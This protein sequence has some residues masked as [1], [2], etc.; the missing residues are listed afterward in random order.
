MAGCYG[1]KRTKWNQLPIHFTEGRCAM[2]PPNRKKKH[3]IISQK[4]NV[5][6]AL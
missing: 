2:R 5:L 3:I 6:F 1:T 4:I